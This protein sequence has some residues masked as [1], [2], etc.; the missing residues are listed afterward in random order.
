VN[1]VSATWEPKRE[2]K[3]PDDLADRPARVQ[4]CPGDPGRPMARP[5]SVTCRS[6]LAALPE[7][8]DRDDLC[9][10]LPG[11]GRPCSAVAPD[12]QAPG[13]PERS[14]SASG[15]WDL[16]DCSAGLPVSGMSASG[17]W[18]CLPMITWSCGPDGLERPGYAGRRSG[19]CS[20]TLCVCC[21]PEVTGV[22][23]RGRVL[24]SRDAAEGCAWRGAS[25]ASRAEITRSSRHART[26]Q[27]RDAEPCDLRRLPHAG[28]GPRAGAGDN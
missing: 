24:S 8:A 3:T 25:A 28:H 2:P 9:A 19:W 11:S 16:G 22:A 13:L 15:R 1:P 21:L 17:R 6:K 7:T 14:V 20:V 18:L 27:M 10:R 5:D 26:M 23:R 12:R 4:H